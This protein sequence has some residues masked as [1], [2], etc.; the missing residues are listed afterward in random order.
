MQSLLIGL[1]AGAIGYLCVTFHFQPILR[2]R[3]IRERVHSDLIYFADATNADALND[4]MKERMWARVSADRRHSSD[5]RAVYVS[6]PWWY[7]KWLAIR[8]QDPIQAA[9]DLMGLSNTFDHDDAALRAKRIR[10][11]LG[12][13]GET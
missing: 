2:F 6:L 8:S 11:N 1:A 12:L 9:R 4:D 13:S 5:L 7:R 10:S 3:E